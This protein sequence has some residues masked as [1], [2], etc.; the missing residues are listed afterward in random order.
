MRL[1]FLFFLCTLFISAIPIAQAQVTHYA[2]RLSPDFDR[3]LLRAEET[4]EF[5]HGAGEIEW[6]KQHGLRRYRELTRDCSTKVT[7]P[8]SQS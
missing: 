5:H 3:Q 2:V 8:K 7:H 1:A 6:Q 4:V